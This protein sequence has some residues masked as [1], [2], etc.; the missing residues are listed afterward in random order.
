MNALLQDWEFPPFDQIKTEDFEPAIHAALE[1]AEHNVEAI[2]TSTE[3]PTFENTVEA[4]E[5]A[6]R[7]LDRVSAI[8]MNLNECCTNDELQAVVMKLE[9]E[10][11]RFSMKVVTDER[12]YERVKSYELR[13]KS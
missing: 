2:A 5:C 6:S 3:E 13:V 12:L 10:M 9:P 7:R 8:M 4:L 1:E 11:T